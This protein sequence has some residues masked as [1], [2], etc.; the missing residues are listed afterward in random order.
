MCTT[1]QPCKNEYTKCSSVC[2][3][4][5]MCNNGKKRLP[6]NPPLC[7]IKTVLLVLSGTVAVLSDT[8]HYIHK[9]MLIR[10]QVIAK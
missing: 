1:V 6:D 10:E 2:C 9:N 7:I 4:N 5:G 3:N 8:G